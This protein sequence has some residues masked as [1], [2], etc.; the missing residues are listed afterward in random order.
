MLQGACEDEEEAADKTWELLLNLQVQVGE[1]EGSS[2]Q[3][4]LALKIFSL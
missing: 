2:S 3:A 1:G 4:C